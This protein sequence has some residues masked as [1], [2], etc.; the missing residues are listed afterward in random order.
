[1]ERI[2]D[3]ELEL[4]GELSEELEVSF[5]DSDI[6][7][8]ISIL[9]PKEPVCAE[10]GLTARE[11]VKMLIDH[12]IGS[13]LIVEGEKLKGIF[14]ERD[15][16]LK[17]AGKKLDLSKV[18]VT[19][20]MTQNPISLNLDDTIARALYLMSLGGYRH[21]PVVDENRYP[22]GIVSVKDIVDYLVLHFP[23]EILNLPSRRQTIS[24]KSREGA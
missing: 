19:D 11:A 9:S 18:Q 13:L 10:Q 5:D 6:R 1:M 15:V 2:V 20:F 7:K 23:K 8:P 21:I 12:K 22:I 3:E 17:I 24:T 16:L 4:M 14:T